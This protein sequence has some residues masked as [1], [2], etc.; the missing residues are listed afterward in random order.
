MEE[1]D[2][3][4]SFKICDFVQEIA[5]IYNSLWV[6]WVSPILQ[7][8]LLT[9]FILGHLLKYTY[10]ENS[11]GKVITSPSDATGRFSYYVV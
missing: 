6:S 5:G 9:A 11:L 10:V 3:Q 2:S 8:N 4:N 1:A 7:G